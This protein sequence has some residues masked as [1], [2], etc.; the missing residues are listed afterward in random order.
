MDIIVLSIGSSML[1]NDDED[2]VGPTNA[3]MYVANELRAKA[4]H[5]CVPEE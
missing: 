5:S 4:N 2:A 3:S 1:L